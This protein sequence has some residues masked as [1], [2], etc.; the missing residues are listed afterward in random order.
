MSA[1]VVNDND[2]SPNIK[3]PLVVPKLNRLYNTLRT[4]DALGYFNDAWFFGASTLN[5][6]TDNF[7]PIPPP[8]A[9]DIRL[10]RWPNG[11]QAYLLIRHFSVQYSSGTVPS[12]SLQCVF[13]DV[14]GAQVPL[15]DFPASSGGTYRPMAICPTP[16]VDNNPGTLGTLDLHWFGGSGGA[17]FTYSLG[18][19]LVYLLPAREGYAIEHIDTQRD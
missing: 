11:T 10:Q 15:G 2:E 5:N 4:D 16:F 12:G 8:A 3:I 17:G 18:F 13:Y 6:G 7:I 9:L 1:F 14:G 19:G